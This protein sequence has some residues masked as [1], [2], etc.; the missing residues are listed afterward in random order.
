MYYMSWVFKNPMKTHTERALC[1]CLGK[2]DL[3]LSPSNVLTTYTCEEKKSIEIC[4]L[5]R[6]DTSSPVD[7]NPRSKKLAPFRC[8]TPVKYGSTPPLDLRHPRMDNLFVEILRSDRWWHAIA[9]CWNTSP[10]CRFLIQG[11]CKAHSLFWL[12]YLPV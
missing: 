6:S 12:K 8:I 9:R 11:F 2:L 10:V 5:W 3:P 7:R 4:C 1:H